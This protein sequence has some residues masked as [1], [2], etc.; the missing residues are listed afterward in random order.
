MTDATFAAVMSDTPDEKQARA[1]V[2]H[3]IG[4][5]SEFHNGKF[6]GDNYGHREAAV[7]QYLIDHNL[8]EI[9][10]NSPERKTRHGK[11][12]ETLGGGWGE[13]K[14]V[15]TRSK[16]IKD[17]QSLGMFDNISD[18]QNYSMKFDQIVFALFKNERLH[19]VY[20]PNPDC[21]PKFFAGLDARKNEIFSKA[22]AADE[23]YRIAGGHTETRGKNKGQWKPYDPDALKRL[24]SHGVTINLKMLKDWCGSNGYSSYLL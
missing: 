6:I 23:A 20:I 22:V 9:S 7:R 13:I 12:F 11:D 17:S 16:V 2:L 15:T 19:A 3:F 14:T 8:C 5:D 4:W 10:S 24:K 18:T 1:L 21:L